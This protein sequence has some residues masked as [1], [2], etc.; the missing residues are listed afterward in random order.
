MTASQAHRA[1]VALWNR[2][3][4]YCWGLFQV[5]SMSRETQLV[6]SIAQPT[7]EHSHNLAAAGAVQGPQKRS[8]D[9]DN[10]STWEA[11]CTLTLWLSQL[12]L[13]PFDLAI[14]DSQLTDA[15]GR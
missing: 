5:C 8:V 1:A 11:L 14:V 15:S 2:R 3:P 7:S 12:V 13:I 10:N 9:D 6:L 4:R